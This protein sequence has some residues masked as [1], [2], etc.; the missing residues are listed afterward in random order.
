MTALLLDKVKTWMRRQGGTTELRALVYMDEI[1]GY[2]PPHPANP[3]TKRPLLTLLKQ[4]RAQGV[5]VVLA[6][7]NPVDLDYKGLAN[8]GTWIV[9]TLQTEQD[10][11]RLDGRPRRARASRARPRPD[12]PRRHEEARVPAARRPPQGARPRSVALGDVVP[13]RAAHARGDLAAD[14]GRAGRGAAAAARRRR[15]A[16]RG[17]AACCPPPFRH[18]Y[19]K[20]SRRR[21]R[22][23]PPAREVRGALQGPGRDGRRSRPGRSPA[24]RRAEALEAE[25]IEV[26]ESAVEPGGARPAC[27]TATCPRG[28]RPAGPRGS[29]RRSRSG[30]PTSSSLTVFRD[31]VTDE[32]SRPGETRDAFAARLGRRRRRRRGPR[33]QEAREEAERPRGPRAGG[34]AGAS[35]RSGSPSAPPCSRTSASSRARSAP[36]PGVGSVLTKNRMEDTAEA[37]LDALKAEVAD[38]EQP[39]RRRDHGRS[40]A[41]SRRRRGAG[42]RRRRRC[43]ATTLVWVY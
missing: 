29:R 28:W 12:A 27:A 30:C 15:P 22:R 21:A 25:P 39:A 14:E 1:F 11:E 37:R 9:G 42:A 34:R 17:A 5:G 18:L 10:R 4:A 20:K 35:R 23:G 40:R 6:T 8:M 24:R 2:F 41:A 16:P 19:L 33:V 7:Q 13:A 36:S 38:L 31:P 26:D 3:P 32:A 43:S